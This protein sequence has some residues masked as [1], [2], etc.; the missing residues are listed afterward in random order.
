L[1]DL[2]NYWNTRALT[3]RCPDLAGRLMVANY[4]KKLNPESLIEIG[5]GPGTL[6]THLAGIP[7]VSACDWSPQMVQRAQQRSTR[8]N[9]GINV[10]LCDI[11]AEPPKGW[12]DMAV[13]R[14]CLMHIPPERIESAVDNV[15]RICGRAVIFE[16][17]EEKHKELAP[18]NWLHDYKRLFENVGFETAECFVRDDTPQALFL[19]TKR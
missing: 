7:K 10:F 17:W 18:H 16:Y 13:T 3:Y 14:T 12:W 2:L 4:V 5:C 11:A 8:H 1:L 19:F 6:F 9:L 15:G